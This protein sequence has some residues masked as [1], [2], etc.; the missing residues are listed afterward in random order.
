MPEMDGGQLAQLAHQ[1]HPSLPV[2]F[3]SGYTGG[4]LETVGIQEDS[5]NFLRKPFRTRE[6]LERVAAIIAERGSKR[7]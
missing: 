2:L 7:V 5:I 6:L 4:V 3:V 1:R